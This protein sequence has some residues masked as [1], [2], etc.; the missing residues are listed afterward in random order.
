VSSGGKD[1]YVSSSTAAD[2]I[3]PGQYAHIVMVYD[4]SLKVYVNGQWDGTNYVNF[5]HNLSAPFIIGGLGGTPVSRI[6]NGQ[7][8]EVLVYTN[9]LTL[10]QVQNHYTR[11]S[12]PTATA[13]Y[14]VALPASNE[15]VSN[16]AATVTLTGTAGGPPP[17]NYQWFKNGVAV[18]GATNTSLTLSCVYSSAGSY[19]LQASNIYALTSNTPAATLA[20][21]PANPSFVNVTNGLVLH[22][23]F[24]GDYQDSSGRGN[25][26]TAIGNGAPISIVP[27]RI[28]SGAVHYQ[29]DTSTGI[30]YADNTNAVVTD[31]S[32]VTL[33]NPADLQ[34]GS[35]TDF[36]VSYWVNLPAGYLNGDLPFFSSAAGSTFNTGFTFAPAYTNG[37]FGFSYNGL[38]LFGAPNS[39]NDGNWHHL[40]HTVSRT[41]NA[42]TYLDGVVVDSRLATSIGNMNTPG[43]V[44][45]GQDPTGLYP[46]QGSATLDDLAV[47]RRSLTAYEAYAIYN[48]ATN[49]NSSFDVPGS[50]TLS[51]RSVGTNV[52]V[53]W[54]TGATLG[55]LMQA[56]NL[57]G[58]WTPVGVYVP[59]Y[60]V[61]PSSARKFYRVNLNESVPAPLATPLAIKASVSGGSIHLS[62]PTQIGSNY[63][64]LYKSNLATGTWLP[65]G[66][67]IPGNGST[68]SV[69]DP[70]GAG[71][72]F[73][74]LQ[75][76]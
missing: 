35:A 70:V 46:E 71:T 69:S 39:I 49:S 1:F 51:I 34:F 14:W 10:A 9:A 74:R 5:D 26:G 38:G 45:I 42:I 48:A 43:P 28:G 76:Q 15:V 31:T 50:V 41:G 66:S 75:V 37:G 59:L 64:V 33:G 19:V 68:M 25:N 63:Q 57:T 27:G 21:L 73:Y 65:L 32:Y 8:D 40:L 20:V 60:Q 54:N 62:F 7:V 72:R 6:F 44:N 3:V 18:T 29:T 17:I 61:P 12:S 11:A 55:T 4:T 47:W 16:A 67:P 2:G 30:P 36:S 56:D 58:P 22:L 24:D 52:V 13:P 53:T 23:K